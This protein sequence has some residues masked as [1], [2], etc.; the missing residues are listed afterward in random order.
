MVGSPFRRVQW[1][2]VTTSTRKIFS[3]TLANSFPTHI[4]E[5]PPNG[6]YWNLLESPDGSL[7]KRSGRK[8]SLLGNISATSC[9]SQML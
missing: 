3:R 4:L 6:M 5:P 2:F 9:V 8:S 1:H 7:R